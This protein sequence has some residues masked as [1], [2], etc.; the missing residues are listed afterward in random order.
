MF[1]KSRDTEMESRDNKMKSRDK[2]FFLDFNVTM[3][4]MITVLW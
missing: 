3:V 1:F 2:V 4:A